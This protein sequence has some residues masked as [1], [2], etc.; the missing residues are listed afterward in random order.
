MYA[1]RTS[2][3]Y[4]RLT[5]QVF[6]RKEVCVLNWSENDYKNTTV[7][8]V[9]SHIKRETSLIINSWHR[10]YTNIDERQMYNCVWLNKYRYPVPND[11]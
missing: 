5:G 9:D 1:L 3:T 6:G 11:R 8:R 4:A 2:K 7:K 10:I